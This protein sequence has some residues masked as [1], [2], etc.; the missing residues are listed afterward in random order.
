MV[1]ILTM[2]NSM[3]LVLGTANFLIR[4]RR[5]LPKNHFL[6]G[7]GGTNNKFNFTTVPLVPQLVPQ[8]RFFRRPFFIESKKRLFFSASHYSL[9]SFGSACKK[10]TGKY[11]EKALRRS[12]RNT[13]NTTAQPALKHFTFSTHA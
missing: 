6:Y 1:Q 8:Y 9:C 12:S 7:K 11:F 13:K 5:Y 4:K 3:Q 2:L 10:A